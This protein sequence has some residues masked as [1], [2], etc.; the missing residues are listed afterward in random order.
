MKSI[1]KFTIITSMLSIIPA[2]A[3][4]DP[5]FRINDIECRVK[6]VND[7]FTEPYL[8][9]ELKAYITIDEERYCKD[10]SPDSL[11]SQH[12]DCSIALIGQRSGYNHDVYYIHLSGENTVSKNFQANEKFFKQINTVAVTCHDVLTKA[13]G[14]THYATFLSNECI[15]YPD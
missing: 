10:P 5:I 6:R 2:H 11:N 4:T 14:I 12:Y 9:A 8:Q 13:R 3:N 7:S 15:I 1:L